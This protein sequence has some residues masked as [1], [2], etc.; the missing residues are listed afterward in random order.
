MSHMTSSKR[1]RTNNGDGKIVAISSKI[2]AS[3]VHKFTNNHRECKIWDYII[4]RIEL[5]LKSTSWHSNSTTQNKV[6]NLTWNS[7]KIDN[8]YLEWSSNLKEME[9]KAKFQA[10]NPKLERL[11]KPINNTQILNFGERK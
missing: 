3:Q 7:I 6:W 1:V 10:N 8:S 4:G 9:N 5:P 2:I 11:K